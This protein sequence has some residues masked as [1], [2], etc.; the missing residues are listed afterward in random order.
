MRFSPKLNAS[1]NS[2]ATRLFNQGINIRN[3][4]QLLGH[5]NITTTSIY[6]YQSKNVV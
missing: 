2:F 1:Y 4:Q 3:V 6:R 5:Q